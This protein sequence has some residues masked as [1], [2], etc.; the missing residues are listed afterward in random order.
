MDMPRIPK[1]TEIRSSPKRELWDAF[2]VIFG[3][4]QL[5]EES[6]HAKGGALDLAFVGERI[7]VKSLTVDDPIGKETKKKNSD[8]NVIR[9]VAKTQLSRDPPVTVTRKVYARADWE[10][11]RRLCYERLLPS[12]QEHT[13]LDEAV[14]A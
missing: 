14:V 10:A 11:A 9:L 4:D 8:H 7:A 3:L 13:T 12:I 2:S 6:T 5:V 1:M